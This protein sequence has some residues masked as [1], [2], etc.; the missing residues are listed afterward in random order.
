VLKGDP[1]GGQEVE[2]ADLFRFTQSVMEL[3]D[4]QAGG[5]LVVLL[6]G[7]YDPERTGEGAVAV[8][9]AL[10]GLDLD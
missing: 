1:L 8:L 7:G 4:E 10:A 5:K 6:E 3:A 2:P 9:R